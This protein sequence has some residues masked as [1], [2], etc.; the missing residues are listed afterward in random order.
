MSS[1]VPLSLDYRSLADPP[2]TPKPL[3]ASAQ[4]SKEQPEN[5]L[6]LVVPPPKPLIPAPNGHKPEKPSTLLAKVG[7]LIRIEST[8]DRVPTF[9]FDQTLFAGFSLDSNKRIL[10][11]PTPREAAGRKHKV[12]AWVNGEG[13]NPPVAAAVYFIEI[14]GNGEL[15]IVPAI[16][17]LE[18]DLRL[19]LIRDLQAGATLKHKE[20]LVFIYRE[21][22]AVLDKRK[23]LKE[24]LDSAK[25]RRELLVDGKLTSTRDVIGRYLERSLP[26]AE[27][28]MT[29]SLRK[30]VSATFTTVADVLEATTVESPQ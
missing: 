18:G 1:L 2:A 9:D 15:S 29:E 11:L 25:T 30:Q 27:T 20:Q 6:P 3:I 24:V 23:T 22:I 14:K 17:S 21:E 4:L 16:P 5:R 10:N 26:A 8:S 12:T 28:A 19:A 13:D 7:N